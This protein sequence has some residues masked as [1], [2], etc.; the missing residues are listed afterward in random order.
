MS[1]PFKFFIRLRVRFNETDLQGHV[2][3]GQYYFYFDESVTHY[4]EAIGY[5]H[6]AMLADQTDLLFAES[7]CNYKSSAKWPEWL[8]VYV[9]VAHLGR[10][11]IRFEFEVQAE[12]DERLVA[13]GHIVA[14]TAHKDTFQPQLVPERLRQ[15]VTAYEKE[16]SATTSALREYNAPIDVVTEA[17]LESFPASDAPPWTLGRENDEVKL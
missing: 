14:V 1:N 13:T 6:E 11:S 8:R 17:D 2:N 12:A 7:H 10:R 4:F 5:D 9:R 15:A 3:F 16:P